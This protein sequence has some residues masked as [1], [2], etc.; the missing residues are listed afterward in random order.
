[1]AELFGRERSVIT[2]HLRNVFLEGELVEKSN[3]QNLHIAS[4]DK[5]VAYYNLDVIIS[6]GYRVK[7]K[8]GPQFRIWATRTLKDH[9]LRG[10]TLNEKRLREK[11]LGELEQAVGL[12]ARTLTQNA[13]VT[14]E[15]RAVLEVVQQYTRAWKLLLEYDEGRLAEAPVNPVKPAAGLS[16][17]DAR[18]VIVRLRESLAVRG[19]ARIFLARSAD[20]SSTA[21]WAPSSR[22]LAVSHS[23]LRCKVGP[24]T[25]S[26]SLSKIIR[27]PTA[28]KESARCSSWNICAAIAC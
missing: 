2:K 10:Y 25:F 20:I 9:L 1:M 3:V 19:E 22:L 11:G 17:N 16:L 28:T 8:R 24:L 4:S 7:S 15:G 14:D 27:S 12:L 18:T 26:I 5:P 21:Y 23:I 6:V 13:L